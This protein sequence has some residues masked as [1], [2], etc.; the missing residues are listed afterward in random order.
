MIFLYFNAIFA[1]NL[2]PAI[3]FAEITIFLAMID[4]N[5]YPFQDTGSPFLLHRD[6]VDIDK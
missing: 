2:T 6:R 4:S 3:H 5:C 1:I